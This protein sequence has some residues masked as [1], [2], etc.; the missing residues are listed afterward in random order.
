MEEELNK[1]AARVNG[2]SKILLVGALIVI[3]GGIGHVKARFGGSQH[4]IDQ[5]LG[6]KYPGFKKW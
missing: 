3:V 2:I 4:T 6:D 5:V 1:S